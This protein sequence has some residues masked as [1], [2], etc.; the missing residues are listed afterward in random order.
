[1]NDEAHVGL[2]D[3]HAE[4]D[5]GHNDVH[6]LGE[7]LVLVFGAHLGLKACVVR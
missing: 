2:V 1:M 7:E 5:G 4:G 3:A 6:L